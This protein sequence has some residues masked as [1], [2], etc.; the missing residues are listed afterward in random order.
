LKTEAKNKGET[1]V[2]HRVHQLFNG[3][4]IIAIPVDSAKNVT[5]AVA[6][7]VG[8]R[9]EEKRFYGAAHFLEHIDSDALPQFDQAE[10]QMLGTEEIVIEPV[11]FLAR[12][13]EHLL[14]ARRKIAHG[15]VAH[16]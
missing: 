6:V 14:R 5:V 1:A 11:G 16:T 12:Q 9:H 7:N 13:R 10:Q 2:N 4:K 3:V 15:F 8:S